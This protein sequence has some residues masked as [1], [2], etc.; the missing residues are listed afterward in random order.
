MRIQPFTAGPY[1]TCCYIVYEYEGNNAVLIDAPYPLTKPLSFVKE[2][3]LRLEAVY[4]THGHFD[5]IFGLAEARKEISDLSVYIEK[6]DLQYVNDGYKGTLE[7]LSS[8]DPFFL[9]RYASGLIAEMPE[10]MMIYGEEAGPFRIIRTPGHTEGSVSL[11]SAEENVLFTG[12]TLF[13]GSVGRTDI[14]GD[15]SKLFSSLKLLSALPSE[16]LV[17][18]G[19]GPMTNIGTEFASNP[20][21]K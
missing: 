6:E 20:Y 10:D 1:G 21:M 16:T 5:H 3:G 11:Y 9:S 12:D 8:F 14:G 15:Q 17:F 13:A 4:L 2:N 7:L 19:H 18:P